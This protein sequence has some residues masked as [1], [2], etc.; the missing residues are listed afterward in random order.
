MSQGAPQIWAVVP[1]HRPGPGS[2]A[3]L[4]G[5]LAP[6]VEGTVLVMNSE[7]ALPP[8]A[9]GAVVDRPGENLGVAAAWNRGGRLARDRGATHLWWFDQD[10]RPGPGMRRALLEALAGPTP[11]AAAGP[12]LVDADL[13]RPLLQAGTGPVV[14]AEV[15][16]SSGCLVAIEAVDDVGELDEDLFVDHVDSDW[17][18]RARAAGYALRRLAACRMEH[19]LGVR[20]LPYWLGRWR[21]VPVH[22][23]VR[24]YYQVRN[25][26]RLYGRPHCPLGWALRDLARQ[27]LAATADL[28]LGGTPRATLGW[29]AAGARD[30]LLGR[31]GPWRP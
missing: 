20:V 6:Q 9:A 29:V 28:V 1:V 16:V 12:T 24:R 31:G 17:C 8:E 19:R 27:V 7:A 10:S 14:D 2:L 18:L 13:A 15:L 21:F 23:G 11:V 3:R 22:H 5:A 25:S 26:L 4:L 30:G